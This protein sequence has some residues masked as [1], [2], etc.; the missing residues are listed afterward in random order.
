M[1]HLDQCRPIAPRHCT[2][3]IDLSEV[4]SPLLSCLPAWQARLARHPDQAFTN[5]ILSGIQYGFRKGFDYYTDRYPQLNAICPRRCN[6]QK[7][8]TITYN[9]SGQKDGSWAPLSQLTYRTCTP[10]EWESSPKDE[11]QGNG[12][13]LPTSHSQKGQG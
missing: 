8:W 11:C 4:S 2:G 9:Q 3:P 1:L 12:G 10:A 6:I 5:Y 7:W 13:S